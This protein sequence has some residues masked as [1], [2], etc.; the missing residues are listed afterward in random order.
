MVDSRAFPRAPFVAFGVALFLRL[1]H[2]H[3]DVASEKVGIVEF[4]RLLRRLGRL[5]RD[6]AEPARFALIVAAQ[7]KV[8][9]LAALSEKLS[10]RPSAARYDRFLTYTVLSTSPCTGRRSICAA[11]LARFAFGSSH[12][13]APWSNAASAAAAAAAAGAPVDVGIEYGER[14]VSAGCCASAAGG[15]TSAGTSDNACIHFCFSGL[16]TRASPR[17][18]VTWPRGLRYG[19]LA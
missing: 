11:S 2:L 4:Q 3:E 19:S 16:P 10:Q 6:V 1:G 13:I 17:N 12:R 8:E 18:L 7:S 15:V 9:N 5:E 14:V